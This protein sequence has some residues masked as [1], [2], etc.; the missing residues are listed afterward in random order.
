[1]T[2]TRTIAL[3]YYAVTGVVAVLAGIGAGATWWTVVSG[4]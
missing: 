4:A 1:M 3:A 2:R